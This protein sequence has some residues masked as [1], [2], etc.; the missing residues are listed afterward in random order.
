M[1]AVASYD[2]ETGFLVDYHPAIGGQILKVN[3]SLPIHVKVGF[4]IASSALNAILSLYVAADIVV[5]EVTWVCGYCHD[6]KVVILVFMD[7][8]ARDHGAGEIVFGK[9]AQT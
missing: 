3:G 5:V 1:P 4:F 8:C 7:V 2:F 6:G 9:T